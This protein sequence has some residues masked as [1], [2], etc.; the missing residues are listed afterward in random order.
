MLWISKFDIL[1]LLPSDSNER[2][3][4]A[5]L[6]LFLSLFDFSPRSHRIRG[7]NRVYRAFP[8]SQETHGQYSSAVS[9]R[10]RYRPSELSLLDHVPLGDVFDF[11]VIQL[12]NAGEPGLRS[13]FQLA[14]YID[15]ELLVIEPDQALDL[16]GVFQGFLV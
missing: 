11:L 14:V 1:N 8:D 9:Q 15:V 2:Y 13:P 3:G 7:A 6:S 4:L 10:G 5:Y 12:A 16:G